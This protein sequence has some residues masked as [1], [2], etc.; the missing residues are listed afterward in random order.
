[1]AYLVK[2]Y[3]DLAIKNYDILLKKFNQSE[4]A[5]RSHDL[6]LNGL[7]KLL[8]FSCSQWIQMPKIVPWFKFIGCFCLF[9]W[10]NIV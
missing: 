6:M 5:L 8:Y 7:L 1:M 3:S 2:N 10:D 9:A 4:N